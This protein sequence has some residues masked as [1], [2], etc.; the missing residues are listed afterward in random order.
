MPESDGAEDPVTPQVLSR[1]R[2][3]R[4]WVVCLG[5]DLNACTL[6]PVRE[7]FDRLMNEAGQPLIVDGT[8]VQSADSNAIELLLTL[9]KETTLIVAAPSPP[10]QKLLATA[11]SPVLSA[12]SLG[13]ALDLIGT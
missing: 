11:P 8:A 3:G 6:P 1:R 12:L 2:R 4:V 9:Q 13:E 5:G 10:L 7:T